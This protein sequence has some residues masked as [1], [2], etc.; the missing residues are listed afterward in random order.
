MP[1]TGKVTVFTGPI[2]Q[3]LLY[4]KETP[5]NLLFGRRIT[6]VALFAHSGLLCGDLLMGRA[7]QR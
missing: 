7:K 3:T 5:E 2:F 4:T 6:G 1:S